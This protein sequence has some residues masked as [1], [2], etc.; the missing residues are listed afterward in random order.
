MKQFIFLCMVVA[1]LLP[2]CNNNK[3]TV[4]VKSEDGKPTA[5]VDDSKMQQLA[6]EIK[7]Q[8]EELQKLPPLTLDELK[9]LLPESI[10]GA[11]R[12]HFEVNSAMGT[13]LANAEYSINDSTEVKINIWDCGGPAGSGY[14]S[15]QY[16][17]LLNIQ[18][19]SDNEYTKTIDF[20][21]H[22]AIENCNNT[23]NRCSLTYFTGKR[24]MVVIEGRNVHPDG[25]KQAA[26]E[27]TI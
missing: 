7:K 1:C 18:S 8:S 19:V 5:S 4:E 17:T 3:K 20:K 13:G 23:N 2:A 15:T 9:A 11:K 14:Y 12:S 24:Y 27:L 6:E 10:M 25:L 22:K 26:N 21:G 16:M